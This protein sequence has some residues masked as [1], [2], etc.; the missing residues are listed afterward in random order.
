MRK[1]FPQFVHF[2]LHALSTVLFNL[3]I[4]LPYYFS[5]NQFFRTLFSPWRNLVVKRTQTGFSFEDFFSR[6]SFNIVSRC[7]GAIMRIII[8]IGYFFILI[9]YVLAIPFIV[10]VSLILLPFQFVIYT[11]TSSEAE[12]KQQYK[13]QFVKTRTLKPENQPQ[14][15]AWFEQYYK[16]FIETSA[17]YEVKN[18]FSTRPIG[19]DWSMGYTPILDKFSRELT[20][21][22]SHFKGLI[23]RQKE[24]VQIE[25]ILT[26]T[27]ETNV[28]V[29]GEE[30]VG[31]HTIIQGLAQ[32]IY[33]G[34]TNMLLAYKRILHLDMEQIISQSTDTAQRE[35][36]I[37]ELFQEAKNAK[38]II[39]LID[40]FDKYIKTGSPVDL[41]TII[42]TY[43]KGN[44]IQFI[45]I[46]TP[47][48][49]QKFIN[50]NETINRLFEKVDVYEISKE[51]ATT[52]IMNN[53]FEIEKK[54][55]CLIP[56]ET[57]IEAVNK[58]NFY[59]TDIPF[60]EKALV[61]LDRAA[62]NTVQIKKQKI[63]LPEVVDEV[64]SQKTHVPV[65]LDISTKERLL[66]LEHLMKDN[67]LFQDEAL[68]GIATTLRKSFVIAAS[69]KKPLASF[70]FLGS[71]GVGKTE[72][73]KILAQIFFKT[74]NALI[75][76]DMSLYQQTSD[77]ANLIGDQTTGNPGLM[78]KAI[79]EKPYGILLL[80]EIEKADKNLLNI[81]LSLLDEGYYTD[82]S[83]KRVDGKNLII[84][85]TSNAGSDY[86]TKLIQ[87]KNTVDLNKKMMTY[88]IEKKIF[89]PE[90]LNRFDGVITFNPLSKEGVKAIGI[91]MLDLIKRQIFD[92][93]KITVNVSPQTLDTLIEKH[94]DPTFGARNLQRLIQYE[95]E[96]KISKMIL[97]NQVKEGGIIN[98]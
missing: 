10:I 57:I 8:L 76:F 82:G 72:T 78:T 21:E 90:F 84:I 64:L 77:I 63:V 47:F 51:E 97:S 6:L 86:L 33:S 25:Q 50:P 70:L 4:F 13:E 69:R 14:V 66:N 18:L 96:D 98:L 44:K 19:R 7:I 65:T 93:Y 1:S 40:N 91:K 88:V 30:G 26:K 71:T 53:V 87:D 83:G 15:E 41:T 20:I 3:F 54:I 27:Q 89:T 43:A 81:F 9:A 29:V 5:V 56:Y 60:P 62:G 12:K 79:R 42:G 59:I 11:T 38:N 61:L 75:R 80:D 48:L 17:W 23:G 28:L 55:S 16:N 73:A 37:K 32:R 22:A 36:T 45:G 39:I 95:I 2:K 85:A 31:K 74:Q 94:Y 67:I 35:E 24:I 92:S 52:I 46:T 49:Y 58:S 34:E 68:I